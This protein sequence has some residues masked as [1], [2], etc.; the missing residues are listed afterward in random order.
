MGTPQQF[1]G[2]ST[3][4]GWCQHRYSKGGVNTGIARVVSTQVYVATVVL[5]V[6]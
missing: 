2:V 3:Q 6:V 1:I 5:T 4:Q